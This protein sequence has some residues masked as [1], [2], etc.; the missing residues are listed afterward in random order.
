MHKSKK[1]D[2]PAKYLQNFAKSIPSHLH[3]GHNLCARYNDTCSNGSPVVLLT[4]FH[5][6]TMH[7]ST[8][9]HN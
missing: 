9:R 1:E 2:N 4:R 3:L 8:K 7:K 5:R 6:C